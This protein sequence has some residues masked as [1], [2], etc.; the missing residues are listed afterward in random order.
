MWQWTFAFDRKEFVSRIYRMKQ[1]IGL[2]RVLF[3]SDFPG[4]SKAMGLREWVDVFRNL[5][6]LAAEHGCDITQAEADAIL[7]GNAERLLTAPSR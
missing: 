4:L 2:D 5:P 6:G 7:G 3:G 1:E